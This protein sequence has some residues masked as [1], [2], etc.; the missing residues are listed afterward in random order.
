VKST[1]VLDLILRPGGLR[2]EFQPIF[3]VRGTDW[4]SDG[5][6]HSL[7]A[8]VRG[9]RGTNLELPSVLFEYVRRQGEES[10]VDQA[11]I[12]AVFQAVDGLPGAPDFS[13]NVHAST[14]AREGDFP[15]FLEALARKKEVKLDRLT[16]EILE[17]ACSWD[18]RTFQRTLAALREAGA[19]VALDDVGLGQSNYR[20]MLD[21]R[22][23]YLKVD[24]YLVE[25]CHRDRH[26]LAVLDSIAHL[27]P[28]LGAQ[29][30]AEGV[31]ELAELETITSLGID[32]VQ[33][34][35]LS[36]PLT[37]LELSWPAE[38]ALPAGGE[39]S[40]LN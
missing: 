19:R 5:Q 36:R 8:L 1:S 17:H 12:A 32:L 26:R 14:L 24:R 6:V 9:P 34:F 38:A 13:V 30:V 35:L 10:L 21:C 40:P 16:V 31:E 11:C 39:A 23:D 29:V 28:R 33:G 18:N 4:G 25:G 2:A 3:K 37:A 27:A 20:M 15:G 7:E 22:P